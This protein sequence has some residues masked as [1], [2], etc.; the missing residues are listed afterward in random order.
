MTGR[1]EP[2]NRAASRLLRAAVWARPIAPP[3]AIVATVLSGVMVVTS[4]TG[5][6]APAALSLGTRSLHPQRIIPAPRA[7]LAATGPKA[8]GTLWAVAGSSS[9][10]L[11]K[12]S[13]ASGLQTASMSVSAAARSVAQ[14]PAGVIAVALGSQTSGA[15]ELLRNGGAKKKTVPLPA[16]PGRW[17]RPAQGPASMC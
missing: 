12:L 5:G 4:C 6:K 13:S 7:L 1:H 11:F 9:V 10:G 17:C 3:A 15:L 14:N 2:A 16:R 8:D